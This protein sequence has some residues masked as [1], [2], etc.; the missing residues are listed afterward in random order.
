MEGYGSF[1]NEDPNGLLLQMVLHFAAL[2][3]KKSFLTTV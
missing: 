1:A 3:K 2:K